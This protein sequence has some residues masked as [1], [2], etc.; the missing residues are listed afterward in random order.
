MP[1]YTW[2]GIPDESAPQEGGRCLG[3]VCPPGSGPG[4]IGLFNRPAPW[5]VEATSMGGKGF[6]LPYTLRRGA[7]QRNE[8]ANWEALLREYTGPEGTYIRWIAQNKINQLKKV[9][10][11]IRGL[12]LREREPEPMPIPDWMQPFVTTQTVEPKELPEG[13]KGRRGLTQPRTV[14]GLRPLGAQTE[15]N[16]EQMMQMAG[17][18]ASQKGWDLQS[19]SDLGRFWEPYTRESEAMF[20]RGATK[21]RWAT[22]VQR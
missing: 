12:N 6:H 15:L 20:S 19:K 7:E 5:Q 2:Q 17:L 14:M 11:S 1:D 3:G 4:N 8:I 21:P 22:A 16:P 13:A 9:E 18:L 10:A